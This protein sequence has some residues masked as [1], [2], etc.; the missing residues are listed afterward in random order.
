MTIEQEFFTLTGNITGP[1]GDIPLLHPPSTGL[2]GAYDIAVD[3]IGG[4]AQVLGADYGLTGS[5]ETGVLTYSLENSDIKKSVIL[6]GKMNDLANMGVTGPTL[7]ILY[8][9][10][11]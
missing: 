5:S 8:N 3:V 1:W 4:P 9:F 7:R 6:V 10:P 11:S 2:D